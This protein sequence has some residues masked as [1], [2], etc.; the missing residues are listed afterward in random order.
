M[1]SDEAVKLT[2]ILKPKVAVPTHY[3]M[4]ENNTEDPQKYIS[5]LENAFE[6]EHNR[7]YDVVELLTTRRNIN[8]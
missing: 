6:M 3:G 5:K 8:G 2:E 4:F 1:T 7:E